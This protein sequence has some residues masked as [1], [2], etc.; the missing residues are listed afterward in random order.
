[1][2]GEER[3]GCGDCPPEGFFKSAALGGV[4]DGEFEFSGFVKGIR[5]GCTGVPVTE[6]EAG[7]GFCKFGWV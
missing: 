1:M 7:T 5:N 4:G 6:G 2:T 3:T